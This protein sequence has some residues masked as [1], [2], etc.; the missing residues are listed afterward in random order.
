MLVAHNFYQQRLSFGQRGVS[1]RT[2]YQ[3]LDAK[4][5][6]IFASAAKS[7]GAEGRPFCA[8]WPAPRRAGFP[9]A[10]PVAVLAA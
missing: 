9:T 4:T 1:A 7:N 10:S 8:A 6:L 5:C 2:D 3:V